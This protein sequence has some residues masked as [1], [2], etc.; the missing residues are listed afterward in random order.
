MLDQIRDSLSQ[1]KRIGT[2]SVAQN[3]VLHISYVYHDKYSCPVIDLR[4]LEKLYNL[5]DGRILQLSRKVQPAIPDEALLSMLG[6]FRATIALRNS[7]GSALGFN[8][9]RLLPFRH[10]QTGIFE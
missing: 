3:A 1:Q 7:I 10:P 4:E 6:C 2:A 8:L 9:P 5:W